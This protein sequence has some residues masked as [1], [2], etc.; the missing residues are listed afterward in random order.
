RAL[1]KAADDGQHVAPDKTTIAD[2]LRGWLDAD[3]D[4][5]P[6]TIERYRQLAE[7]QIIP[8]LGG[9]I[10][11]NLRPAR[12]GEWHGTLLNTGGRN[13]RALSA[14]TVGHA[15]RVLR[16][17][18]ERAL[19]LEIISRNVAAVIRPPKVDAAEVAILTAEQ[20]A[21]VLARLEGHALYPVVVLAL[22]TG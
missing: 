21:D 3:T 9:I 8:H 2:Y 15:H 18:L 20:M 22:G 4:L 1:L 7:Q 6:K 12:G 5:A 17:G 10:L 19:R 14:G 16:R 11:Q 13:G